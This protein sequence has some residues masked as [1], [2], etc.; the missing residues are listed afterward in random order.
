MKNIT[1]KEKGKASDDAL[2]LIVKISE[3]SVRDSLSLLD[4]ALLSIEKGQELDLKKAQDIFGYFDKS[5]LI[6]IFELILKGEEKS[7]W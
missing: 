5:L 6:E 7:N 4:K 1:N 2:K 3:G